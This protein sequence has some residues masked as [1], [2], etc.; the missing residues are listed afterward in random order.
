MS[1]MLRTICRIFNMAGAETEDSIDFLLCTEQPCEDVSYQVDEL[2]FLDH[3][4]QSNVSA[5]S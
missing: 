2:Y 4:N 1:C 3:S 5:T